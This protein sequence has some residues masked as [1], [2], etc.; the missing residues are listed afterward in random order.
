MPRSDRRTAT[1]PLGGVVADWQAQTPTLRILRAFLGGTFLY[2]GVQKLADPTFLRAGSPGSI[3]S[4]LGEFAHGSPIRPL[5]TAMGHAPVLVG[6]SVALVEVA[7]GIATLTGVAPVS[8]ALAGLAI[9]VLLWLSATWHV[10][11]YF[12]GSDSIYAV[13][14]GAYLAGVARPAPATGRSVPATR[15]HRARSRPAPDPGRRSLLRGA[16]V[17]AGTLLV[18]AV[19]RTAVGDRPVRAAEALPSPGTRHHGHRSPGHVRS[20][21]S[22]PSAPAPS[23]TP[24]A[25]LDRIPVGGAIAFQDPASGPAILVR[26]GPD[27][28]AAFS[29]VC[30]HAGCLVGYDSASKLIVC[31][32]HGAEFDPSRGARVVAGPAP[33]ALQEVPVTVDNGSGQVLR[34]D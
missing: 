12:L 8:A 31:P 27:A 32:C 18:A 23:G 13:A 17:A 24:I 3:Q 21:G 4:Q 20:P 30:T 5:I 19:S 11:P 29:R 7:I 1:P 25:S 16:A 2:A 15:S 6:V 22:A 10:H 34:Q 14:W 26:T 33:A 28:V 9:N